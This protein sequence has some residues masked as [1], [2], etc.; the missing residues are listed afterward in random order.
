MQGTTVNGYKFTRLFGKGGMAK[1]GKLRMGDFNNKAEATMPL[2]SIID[3][4]SEVIVSEV[5][6]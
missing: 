5:S 1:Y 2:Y 6:K 4:Y 3:R